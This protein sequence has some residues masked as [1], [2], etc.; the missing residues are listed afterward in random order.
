MANRKPNEE[1]EPVVAGQVT[2]HIADANKKVTADAGVAPSTQAAE[3]KAVQATQDAEQG[4]QAAATATET[5]K[6]SD[7]TIKAENEAQRSLVAAEK[8]IDDARGVKVLQGS[9]SE[10]NV[11]GEVQARQDEANDKGAEADAHWDEET[12]RNGGM[13]KNIQTI[14]ANDGSFTREDAVKVVKA[15]DDVRAQRGLSPNQRQVYQ[16]APDYQDGKFGNDTVQPSPQEKQ[17]G[18][19]GAVEQKAEPSVE[20]TGKPKPTAQPQETATEKN[21][22]TETEATANV[23]QPKA[24]DKGKPKESAERKG[25]PVDT[26]VVDA[27]G[28]TAE[29][30]IDEEGYERDKSG[31]KVRPKPVSFTPADNSTSQYDKDLADLEREY[32]KKVE[33]ATRK[34]DEALER[35]MDDTSTISDKADAIERMAA[36]DEVIKRYSSP[37]YAK[38]MHATKILAMLSDALSAIGNVLTATNGGVAMKVDSASEKARKEERANEAALQKRIDYWTKRMESARSSDAKASNFLRSR[39]MTSALEA[40]KAS[41]RL[42]KDTF[43]SGVGALNNRYRRSGDALKAAKA[44]VDAHNKRAY[45]YEK[46]RREQTFKHNENVYKEK[47]QNRRTDKNNATKIKTQKMRNKNKKEGFRLF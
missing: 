2:D 43:T 24:D 37:G 9:V 28:R 32:T 39:N 25:R 42:A 31:N 22:K 40:Y 46:Q 33:E 18:D 17:G 5:P 23:E 34:K 20:E 44:T 1:I 7:S 10:G 27:K 35:I 45:D 29:Q 21:T 19:T 30:V 8:T 14:G 16:Y 3:P 38:R 6:V 47:Q 12:L 26:G 11:A 13:Y 36:A 15:L 4:A 41:T